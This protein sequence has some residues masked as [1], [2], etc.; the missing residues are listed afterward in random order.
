[1]VLKSRRPRPSEGIL[2]AFIEESIKLG[3]GANESLRRLHDLGFGMR[4]GEFLRWF[5]DIGNLPKTRDVFKS[6]PLDKTFSSKHYTINENRIRGFRSVFKIKAIRAD[7]VSGEKIIT[8]P[9][10][11]PLTKRELMHKIK[12]IA[13]GIYIND[14]GYVFTEGEEVREGAK[15]VDAEIIQFQGGSKG[16]LED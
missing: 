8:I 9:H 1:M 4:R 5:R 14:M 3:R 2:R 16:W 10:N 15:A 6:L 7:G 12:E 11:K 13:K